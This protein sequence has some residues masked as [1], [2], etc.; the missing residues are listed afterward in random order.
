LRW[1]ERS[2]RHAFFR[3]GN[4]NTVGPLVREYLTMAIDPNPRRPGAGPDDWQKNMEI[5]A[6]ADG[7]GGEKENGGSPGRS[8]PFAALA[9]LRPGKG[10]KGGS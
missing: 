3:A 1:P 5:T 7:D 4:V 10:R 6:K 8:S 9:A 2:G